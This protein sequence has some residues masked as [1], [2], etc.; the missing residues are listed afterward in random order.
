MQHRKRT[1]SVSVAQVGMA[2]TSNPP[3]N[4]VHD[5][6]LDLLENLKLKQARPTNANGN[7]N[8]ETKN[9]GGLAKHLAQE[10]KKIETLIRPKKN[11]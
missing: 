4:L 8:E 9:T 1:L 7:S 2:T 6:N 10:I 3:T 11:L 5:M